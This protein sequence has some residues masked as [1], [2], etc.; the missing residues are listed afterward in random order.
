M[1]GSKLKK[2]K[3]NTE[4]RE[5][6]GLEQCQL[7][8][9]AD[10]TRLRGHRRKTWLDCVVGERTVCACSKRTHSLGFLFNRPLIWKSLQV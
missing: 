1:C 3:M 6:L 9:E 10:G 2:R 5:L 8:M 7:P 4:I